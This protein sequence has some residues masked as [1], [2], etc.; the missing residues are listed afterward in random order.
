MTGANARDMRAH[1]SQLRG[2]PGDVAVHDLAGGDSSE[3]RHKERSGSGTGGSGGRGVA[4]GSAGDG[5]AGLVQTLE[6]G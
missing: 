1:P 6:R 5:A 4:A 2:T 3:W